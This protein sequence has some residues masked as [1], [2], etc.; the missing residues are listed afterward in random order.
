MMLREPWRTR[1]LFLS[2][3]GNLFAVALV[4]SHV[5]MRE[6]H[7]PPGSAAIVDHMA[8]EMPPDDAVR[9]RAIMAQ[10]REQN[11]LAHTRMEDARRALSRA[12]G[13]TPYDED[14]VRQAM[15]DWQQAWLNWSN[16]LGASLLKAFAG[17]SPDGRR[18]L[19]EAGQRH[20]P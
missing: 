12:I 5:A 19:A 4:G 14:A 17:L 3:A 2:V 7:K 16:D 8:R 9:F 13:R 10:G 1:L 20:G 18:R 11:D 15:H 6:P